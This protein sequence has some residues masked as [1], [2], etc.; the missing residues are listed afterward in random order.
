MFRRVRKRQSTC[1]NGYDLEESFVLPCQNPLGLN[2]VS[3]EKQWLRR[4]H[5]HSVP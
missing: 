3:S 1:E 5:T 2:V 4:E